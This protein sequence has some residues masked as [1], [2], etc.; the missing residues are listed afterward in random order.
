MEPSHNGRVFLM[1]KFFGVGSEHTH[2]TTHSF[3]KGEN[4][5]ATLMKAINGD[6]GFEGYFFLGLACTIMFWLLVYVT[7]KRDPLCP[8]MDLFGM[9]LES[10]RIPIVWVFAIIALC[11]MAFI[12]P[13]TSLEWVWVV[14]WL[15]ARCI[16][17]SSWWVNGL[18]GPEE[19]RRER[20]EQSRIEYEKAF[21][22]ELDS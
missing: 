17:P 18:P 14:I 19:R 1:P 20:L 13:I 8:N 5:M 15:L 22:E 11:G 16:R 7:E 21:Q 4:L 2:S 9:F 10:R 6:Y 12:A 3:R